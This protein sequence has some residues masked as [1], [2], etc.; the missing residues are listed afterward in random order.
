MEHLPMPQ[1]NDN[2]NPY[3]TPA[4]ADGARSPR[5][6]STELVLRTLKYVVTTGFIVLLL[7][8]FNIVGITYIRWRENDPLQDAI[9]SVRV[10][11]ETLQLA[12]GRQ[13]KDLFLRE[14]TFDRSDK[15]VELQ[16]ESYGNGFV[17]IYA[18][19]RTFV[20]G[21]G[22]PLVV[23]PIVPVEMPRYQRVSVGSGRLVMNGRAIPGTTATT[24]AGF[25]FE[26][27][28]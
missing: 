4:A 20:C 13:L 17:E 7:M 1:P 6:E 27:A 26:S 28:E 2:A 21:L 14:E 24:P 16:A 25:G 11:Q 3:A 19:Q 15:M 18:K 5:A 9:G 23:I 12:D 10:D 8:M 22:M